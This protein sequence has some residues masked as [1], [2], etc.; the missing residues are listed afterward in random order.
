M[1]T[2]T[3]EVSGL[4]KDGKLPVLYRRW[5]TMKGRCANPNHSR[6]RYYGGRGITI[7]ERWKSFLN[8]QS[9][10]G[11]TFRPGLTLER[12][13]NDGPYSPENCVWASW[14]KQQNNKRNS[15]RLTFRGETHTIAEWARLLKIRPGLIIGRLWNGFSVERALATHLFNESTYRY[16]LPRDIFGRFTSNR[17]PLRL[18]HD[19]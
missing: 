6:Y 5:A 16:I 9:D 17:H 8:F 1:S 7:C 3:R 4:F 13:D 18:R 15:R 2:R 19:V 14:T 11:P 10:M 12:L